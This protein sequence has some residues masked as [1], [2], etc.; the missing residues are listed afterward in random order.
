MG[1]KNQAIRDLNAQ[2]QELGKENNQHKKQLQ[3]TINDQNQ[4]RESFQKERGELEFQ[5]EQLVQVVDKLTEPGTAQKI[6]N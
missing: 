6:F 1:Q 5:K 3:Q 4:E 2:L